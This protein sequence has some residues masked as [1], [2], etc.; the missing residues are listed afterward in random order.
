LIETNALLELLRRL[1]TGAIVNAAILTDVLPPLIEWLGYDPTWLQFEYTST[2]SDRAFRLLDAAVVDPNTS[3]VLVVCNVKYTVPAFFHEKWVR[4][5]HDLRKQ[6]GAPGAVLITAGVLAVDAPSVK[7][8]RNSQLEGL[9]LQTLTTDQLEAVR[10]A[11]G[12]DAVLPYSKRDES[13]RVPDNECARL[14]QAATTAPTNAAKKE[15]LE[16]LAAW[17]LAQLPGVRVKRQDLRTRSAEIDIVAES[18]GVDRRRFF[19][20]FG[21]YFLVECKNWAEPV[22]AKEIRDFVMKLVKTNVRLGL[23]VTR[24]G[25]TAG[26]GNEDAMR[27]IQFCHDVLHTS[28]LVISEDEIRAVCR[29]VDLYD[30]LDEKLDRLRF[31]LRA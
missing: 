18:I 8:E 11:I 20:D 24:K 27:E 28:V 30:I 14:L 31:D 5:L 10:G 26:S 2:I 12:C 15:S 3:N 19:D 1:P 6:V 17:L 22:G 7:A 13:Q 4:Q 9:L 23:F 25:I 29:G 16:S 21:R